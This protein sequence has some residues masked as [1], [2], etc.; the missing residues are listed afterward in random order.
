MGMGGLGTGFAR[1]VMVLAA[2]WLVVGCASNSYMG[3]PLDAPVAGGLGAALRNLAARAQA[4]DKHAQLELGI[5]F[6]EGRE[7][8]CNLARAEKLYRLAAADSGGTMW[9][10]SPPVREGTSGRVLPLDRGP[11]VNGL[12]E[13]K[14]RLLGLASAKLG[15]GCEPREA[16]L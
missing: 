1:A 16:P 14:R 10:Y 5:A 12:E 3:I 4:G 6:E 2:G 15:P 9:V 7:V 11:K 8:T 13:A